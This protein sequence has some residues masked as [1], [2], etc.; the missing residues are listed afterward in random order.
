M[1]CVSLTRQTFGDSLRLFASLFLEDY[2]ELEDCFK[3]SSPL[4]DEPFFDVLTQI[5]SEVV[6]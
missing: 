5:F 2:L 3:A 6:N 4:R 1:R